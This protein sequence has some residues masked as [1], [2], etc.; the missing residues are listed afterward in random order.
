VVESQGDQS[1]AEN[2]HLCTD[3]EDCVTRSEHIKILKG[4]VA[5]ESVKGHMVIPLKI[6]NVGFSYT[7]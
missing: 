3:H 5:K 1:M 4:F 7:S 2:F 6:S